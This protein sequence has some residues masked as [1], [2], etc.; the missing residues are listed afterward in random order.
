GRSSPLTRL[1]ASATYRAPFRGVAQSGSAFGSGPKGRRFESSRP[2]KSKG[3]SLASP[4]LT[5]SPPL[6]LGVA[7]EPAAGGPGARARAGSAHRDTGLRR[8]H[9]RPVSR[10][11]VLIIDDDVKVCDYS[12]ELLSPDGCEVVAINDPMAGLEKLK[13]KETFHILILDLKMPGITGL[14]LLEK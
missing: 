12:Q 7:A 3:G 6:A 10:L 11:R 14:E 4:P 1:G 2:E 9:H 8:W 13:A 5:F